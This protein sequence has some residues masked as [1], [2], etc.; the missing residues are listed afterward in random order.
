MVH[1]VDGENQS[2]GE[3]DI[4]MSQVTGFYKE[5][6][7]EL[8]PKQKPAGASTSGEDAQQTFDGSHMD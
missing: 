1:K 4:T 3:D 6:F 5:M 2:E 8:K 7:N